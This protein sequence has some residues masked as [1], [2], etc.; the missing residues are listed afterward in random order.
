[1]TNI[2]ESMRWD[3]AIPMIMRG[4]KVEG[5]RAAKPNLQAGVLA[6][7]TQ[8]L[9]SELEKYS[10]TLQAGEQPYSD[11]EAAQQA[12]NDGKILP[13]AK[14]SVRSRQSD[15]WV[16]EYE[17]DNGIA[18]PSGKKLPSL[19][20][21]NAL[22]EMVSEQSSE[23]MMF[24]FSD[25]DDFH[26]ADISFDEET[27]KHV[28]NLGR[29][30]LKRSAGA[31]F[32][33]TD[34]DG[35][36][37]SV[38]DL[39]DR[40]RKL[41]SGEYFYN[42]MKITRSEQNILEVTDADGFSL[43][44]DDILSR[45][46]SVEKGS[47]DYSGQSLQRS[48]DH[49]FE[50]KDPDGFTLTAERL[51]ERITALENAADDDTDT[52]RSGETVAYLEGVASAARAAASEWVS[53]PVAPLRKGL[54]LFFIY[55]QSL[56]I[57]DEAF[58]VVTRQPSQLGNLMLGKAVRGT[59]YGRTNDADFGV[60]GGENI[61][62]PLTEHRQDGANIITDPGRNTRLGETV[63][64]GFM[65]TLKMLHNRAKGV[66][67][68]EETILACSVT[69]CSGTNLAT[70]LK[71]AATP[72][73]E[74]L[75]SALRGHM[76]AAAAM[77]ITDI[78]VCGMLFL[79]GENDYGNTTRESFLKMLNQLIDDFNTDARAITGQTDNPG[80]YLYQTGGQY[81][82]QS[83][84]NTLPIDMA[85]LD[86]T[87]RADAFMAAPMFP[88]P[89][90]SNSRTHKAANSYRWW[91]CAAANTVFRVLNNENRMPFRMVKAVYDGDDIYVSF[92]T[93]CPPLAVQPYY[94]VATPVMNSDMGFTVIDG[95]GNLYGTSLVTEIISPC[96]I[97]IS[98][99]RK[100]S[101]NIRL[102]LGDQLHGGGHNVADSSPQ[103]SFFNWQYYGDD[104]QSVNE[105]I[106]ALN[107]K[108]YPLYNF[109]AIQTINVDGVEL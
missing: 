9:R 39:I 35:F 17:N 57:G 102:N 38:D 44:I 103:Q 2:N 108:P 78:Q 80:F 74:R 97:K 3:D 64:S 21:V 101:G 27:G 79:Q 34:P 29:M 46:V 1:M 60:I 70:L 11:A 58:S 88:Y 99:P 23:L 22:Q 83:Q 33:V 90:A 59:Y 10:G 43:S 75:M 68:D 62:Y 85:Q 55:G 6:N 87:S 105:N 71:G 19:E 30:A 95:T 50:I 8:Y 89:Q 107:D 24:L 4:D 28:F 109:A 54:N 76:E 86:I 65:E 25:M 63:A 31:T 36:R 7:R 26:V 96:V 69:G 18:T 77:G 98:P 73:Y 72:Y 81:V 56:A 47:F 100:L 41:E 12:I 5:G 93:P 48:P 42:G 51:I 53:P 91:G 49:I 67:N 94:R 15:A 106:D 40:L 61:Y 16:D 37:M 13:G 52:S 84:G 14:F 32:E 92:M 82:S 45:L 20:A 66:K 104:N